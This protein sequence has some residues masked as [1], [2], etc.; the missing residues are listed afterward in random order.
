[1]KPLVDVEVRLVKD[2]A[3]G[4]DQ[5]AHKFML[6]ILTPVPEGNMKNQLLDVLV[7]FE[8]AVRLVVWLY[9]ERTLLK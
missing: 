6:R 2:L 3:E 8:R 5:V 9:S 1:M 7:Q 4:D